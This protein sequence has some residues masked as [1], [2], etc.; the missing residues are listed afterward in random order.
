MG[1][2]CGAEAA[3]LARRYDIGEIRELDP[4]GGTAGRTYRVATSTGVYFLRRRGARSSSEHRVAFDHSLRAFLIERGIRTVAPLRARDGSSWLRTD[5]G[6]WEL[7]PFV[8]GRGHRP[9]NPTEI[10]SV[11]RELGRF[12]LATALLRPRIPE[13]P[14]LDQFSLS[15][16]STP[17][18]TR[19]DDPRSMRHAL[20]HC[21]PLLTPGEREVAEQMLS[22]VDELATHFAA[23]AYRR[24]D[25]YVIHGDLHR[26]NVLF[27]PDGELKGIFDFDWACCAP[28]LRD[29]AEA[30]HFF[31]SRP[32]REGSDIWALTSPP[33]L[34]RAVAERLLASYSALAPL[35][36]EEEALLSWAWMGR[37]IGMR[38]EGMYKVPR[39][40]RGRF[41]TAGF[42]EPLEAIMGPR[43][44]RS[45]AGRREG[46]AC[47]PGA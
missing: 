22:L 35:D 9:G 38:I 28:R 20:Q 10:A 17:P 43:P 34:D 13:P 5:S 14:L 16:S 11:A 23:D 29:L 21:I 3:A 27:G 24:L 31:A 19:I 46:P 37:W 36:P 4:W 40:Q 32:S 33:V 12:H 47:S 41:L 39:R 8:E 30:L 18:S 2:P 25:R 42:R 1:Y 44:G 7:Y 26:G 45:T 6:V 15:V